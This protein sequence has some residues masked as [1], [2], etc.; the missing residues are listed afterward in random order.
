MK[1][2]PSVPPRPSVQQTGAAAKV[3]SGSGQ[4]LHLA[5]TAL[6]GNY[7]KRE[8]FANEKDFRS[9]CHYYNILR[10]ICRRPPQKRK[11]EEIRELL[12]E[13][14]LSPE[15]S[16]E[17][18]DLLRSSQASQVDRYLIQ[19]KPR[20]PGIV[21]VHWRI[22]VTISTSFISRALTPCVQLLLSL[23]DGRIYEVEMNLQKFHQ[24][25]HTIASILKEMQ[26]LE[27]L[28]VMQK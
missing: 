15:S 28:P 7:P 24:L 22:S 10:T 27:A 20:L 3:G 21:D 12:Q 11:D 13:L 2:K 5:W 26:L 17:I 19:E 18:L 8:E 4:P 16:Q 6:N 14:K 1:E 23:S 9:F 25:R